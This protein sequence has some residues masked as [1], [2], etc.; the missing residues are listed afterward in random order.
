MASF[1]DHLQ[2]IKGQI[3]EITVDDLNTQLEAGDNLTVLDIREPSEHANGVIEG[4]TLVP[5]GF[6][7]LK[8]ESICPDRN[9]AIAVC[10][11]GG[12]RSALGAHSLQQLGYTRVTSVAGGIG[13]WSRA[14]Y[15]LHHP[16]QM[17]EGQL[18]RYARQIILPQLGEEGQIKLLESRVLC[19]G[20]GGLGS[21][22]AL[23]LAAA[24]S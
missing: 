8:V 9:A 24:G 18:A 23:Y 21:P 22:T 14:G 19:V 1:Q 13:A 3:Q 4:S 12:V 7:E 10:C 15:P 17:D 11:A 16:K 5:R 2:E 20:A 6:L